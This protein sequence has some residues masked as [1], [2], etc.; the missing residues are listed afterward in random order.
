M[1][2]EALD[3]KDLYQQFEISKR[4]WGGFVAKSV[5]PDG[6]PPGF[7]K[8][9]GWR[10]YTSIPDDFQLSEAPGLDAR[11]RARLP[12]FHFPLQQ[13][14]SPPVVVGKWYCPFMF[15]LTGQ[16]TTR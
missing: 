10:V 1:E 7:L 3:P 6:F 11:L 14:C 5:A 15:R 8:R 16:G 9:K 2:P 12:D 13:K 4:D